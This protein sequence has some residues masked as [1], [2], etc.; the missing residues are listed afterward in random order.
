M[1]FKSKLMSKLVT[2]ESRAQ[3]IQDAD[4]E[5]PSIYGLTRHSAALT[6]VDW[7]RNKRLTKPGLSDEEREGVQA[8]IDMI[9]KVHGDP[10]MWQEDIRNQ[11]ELDRIW[12]RQRSP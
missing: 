4:D 7:L 2:L 11:P 12:G 6:Y 3:E 8:V 1:R 5:P 10:E 9:M